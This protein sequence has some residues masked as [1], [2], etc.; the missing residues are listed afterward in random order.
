MITC[1]DSYVYVYGSCYLLTT[2]AHTWFDAE[3]ACNQQGGELATL[4]SAAQDRWIYQYFSAQA[5]SSI[6]SSNVWMG[7]NQVLQTGAFQWLSGDPSTF[8]YWSSSTNAYQDCALLAAGQQGTWGLD[9]CY[10][11][12]RALCQWNESRSFADEGN[13]CYVQLTVIEAG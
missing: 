13:S 5:V 9:Y 11:N 6:S 12:Y 10:S 1:P 8:T 7:Y 3:N 2:V 4:T